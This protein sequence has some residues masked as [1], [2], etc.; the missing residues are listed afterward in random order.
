[1]IFRHFFEFPKILI[2]LLVLAVIDVVGRIVGLLDEVKV[3]EGLVDVT[4]G[5]T[6][7]LLQSFLHRNKLCF[8]WSGFR[9]S[10]YHFASLVI[11]IKI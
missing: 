9:T 3:V 5:L 6:G 1:M 10:K 7:N 2:A 4:R 8:I 11:L